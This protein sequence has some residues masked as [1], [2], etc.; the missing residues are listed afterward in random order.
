MQNQGLIDFSLLAPFLLGKCSNKQMSLF[1]KEGFLLGH[2]FQ[3][4]QMLSV[5]RKPAGCLLPGVTLSWEIFSPVI[6]KA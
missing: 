5:A 1:L 3:T 2:W 6:Q 4:M